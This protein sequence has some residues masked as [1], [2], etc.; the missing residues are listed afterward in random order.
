MSD[1]VDRATDLVERQI[2]AALESHP[3]LSGNS[4][5]ECVKC[6]AAINEERR[7]ALVGVQTCISCQSKLE[8][9]ARHFGR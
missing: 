5:K 7:K 2:K 3:K 8:L 1:I 4:L 6:G 9:A